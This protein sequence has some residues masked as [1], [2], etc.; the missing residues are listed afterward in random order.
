MT[1]WKRRQSRRLGLCAIL[2]LGL[3]A[4]GPAP[5][6]ADD[7][8]FFGGPIHTGRDDRPQ[9]EAV[10][11]AGERI[12][13]AGNLAA[14]RQRMA[15]GTREID[16]RGAAL[17]PGFTDSHA[18]LYGIGL[19][20]LTLNLEGTASIAELKDR[21]AAAAAKAAPG[22]VIVGRGW[23][24][25]HWPE[26]RFPTRQD[27]DAVAPDRPVI[28]TRA[29]G[30]ALVA[31]S[32]ALA[33]AG[34]TRDTE[35]PFGGD[36]LKDETGEPT[37]MIIDA[38]MGLLAPLLRAAEEVDPH[39]VYEAAN[40]VYTARG[41]TGIH[42]MSV[43]P[44]RLDL[45]EAL[46]DAGV[47]KLRIYNSVDRA[48]AEALLESGPR[49]SKN[50]R[51]TTRAI[52]LYMDGALGSRGAALLAPYSDAPETSGLLQMKKADTMPIL[53]R[54]LER[55]IQVNT[56]AIGDR[57][58]RLAL[59]W[60]AEAFAS[61]PE[62]ARA[63]ANPRW[64]IEHAQILDPADIPRFARLGVIASMQPSH[65]I[66]DLFFA[67]AR[68]GPERLAGAYAWRSLIDSGAVIAAGSDAPVE[69]GDPL[70][71]FYAAVARR[72]LDGFAGPGWHPEQ[73]V[74]RLTALRML[75]LW[76][77]YARFAERDLGTIA[78]GK[79]ADL[80]VFSGDLMSLPVAEIPR[81]KA[82]M[83]VIGGEIVY[84]AAGF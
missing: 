62:A 36:I 76:P 51:V 7:L 21:V 61:V 41:W 65:A 13:F 73:A 23:I 22:A 3:L 30:H 72:S 32:V 82:L 63:V 49:A 57:G 20:E 31:N 37:G 75:T 45:I 34:I 18:H 15:D 52:K 56:H 60:Y 4:A 12:V 1:G 84:R 53:K 48:G 14:A 81:Q 35:P 67:P 25:T 74:D 79:L 66:S 58:N 71:E 24:E 38:A 83:T 17:F 55:G 42:S 27:L 68:L 11:V 10:L 26:A 59:D 5:A 80:T 70:I 39:R 29:D 46:A 28:L 8:L 19:R 44:T 43:D 16:L 9:V 40:R 50:G 54:A 78:A 33:R 77:A 69:R 47:L 2:G 64:R 6:R